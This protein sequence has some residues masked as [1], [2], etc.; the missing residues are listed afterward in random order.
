MT[1]MSPERS[2]IEI[3][4]T[5]RVR[6]PTRKIAEFPRLAMDRKLVKAMEEGEEGEAHE[7]ETRGEVAQIS[8]RST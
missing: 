6:P 7:I 4:A 3:G 2:K 8:E 5:S 1:M